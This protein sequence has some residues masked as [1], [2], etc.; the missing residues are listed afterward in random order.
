MISSQHTVTTTASVVVTA[1]ESWRTIYLHVVGNGVVYLGGAGVTSS[2]G[3]ATEKST[4]PFQMIIPA[5]ET[6]YAVTASGTQ[7]L[8]VLR[9][10]GA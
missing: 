6:L 1:A 9:P 7:D 10:S 3:M 5:N 8:R 4:V 2:T